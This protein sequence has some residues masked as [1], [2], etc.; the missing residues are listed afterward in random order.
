MNTRS[1]REYTMLSPA[2]LL[3]KWGDQR[4]INKGDLDS[5][6][7]GEAG[8][9]YYMGVDLILISVLYRS[10]WLFLSCVLNGTSVV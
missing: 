7:T 1:A 2:Q 8:R 5:S 3:R 4:P 6:V 10:M 9:V